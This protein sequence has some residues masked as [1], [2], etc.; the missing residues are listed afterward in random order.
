MIISRK[1]GAV[2]CVTP[3]LIRLRPKP[4]LLDPH[5]LTFY[6][7]FSQPRLRKLATKAV[8]QAN[9]NATSLKNF[10]IPLPPLEEQRKIAE[11]LSTIDRKLEIERKHKEKLSRI[12]KGLM[13]LLLTGKVRIKVSENG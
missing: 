9:I 11:I 4:E 7:I 3:N 6:L 5:F 10:K 12:K 1:G 8:H 13:D 2:N